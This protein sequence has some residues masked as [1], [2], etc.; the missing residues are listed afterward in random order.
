ML[1]VTYLSTIAYTFT[2]HSTPPQPNL[3]TANRLARSV[4]ARPPYIFTREACPAT[5]RE[6]HVHR[7]L[8]GPNSPHLSINGETYIQ[9]VPR[10]KQLGRKAVSDGFYESVSSAPKSGPVSRRLS[11][12]S[13]RTANW[14]LETR[15]VA[16]CRSSR[17][18]PAAEFRPLYKPYCPPAR[19]PTQLDPVGGDGIIECRSQVAAALIRTK[20]SAFS[21]LP[22]VHVARGGASPPVAAEAARRVLFLFERGPA[23]RQ[24][25]VVRPSEGT[26]RSSVVRRPISGAVPGW[27]KM[28]TVPRRGHV[29]GATRRNAS[30]MCPR[31]TVTVPIL[32]GISGSSDLICHSEFGF[33]VSTPQTIPEQL[34]MPPG[35]VQVAPHG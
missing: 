12:T 29:H 20:V 11:R 3:S 33:R 27:A 16:A 26:K 23:Q 34:G 6:V 30:R 35:T 24:P 9:T 2:H 5:E 22:A 4:R 25:L 21:K 10:R 1:N 17:W 32:S 19:W 18:N 13:L 8:P 7:S 14:E 28:G 15:G 31:R